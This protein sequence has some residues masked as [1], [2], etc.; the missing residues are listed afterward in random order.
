MS[1]VKVFLVH[2]VLVSDG[3]RAEFP[4]GKRELDFRR[5][6]GVENYVLFSD[7]FLY[8]IL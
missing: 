5:G 3:Y 2:D 1:A 4:G 8:Y 6:G 7:F